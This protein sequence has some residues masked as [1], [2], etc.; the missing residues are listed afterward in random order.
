MAETTET[1][2]FLGTGRRKT[3]VA[4][5]YLTE[6]KGNIAI[7]KKSVAEYFPTERYRLAA[8][9]PLIECDLLKKIDVTAKVHGGGI[10]GHAEAFSH[11]VARALCKFD[12]SLTKALRKA[13]FLMRDP[14]MV[15]RKKYGRHKARRSTQF[16]KR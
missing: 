7:N 12:P 8:L 11:G 1:T 5:I 2:V 3:A 9:A 13:G 6:G 14:R 10:T 4:R 15:E 16:S